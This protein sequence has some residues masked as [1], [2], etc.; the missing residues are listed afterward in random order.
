MNFAEAQ[1][2]AT[3]LAKAGD[4]EGID[5]LMARAAASKIPPAL[6]QLLGTHRENALLY[7]SKNPKS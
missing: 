2:K 6:V 4:V 3:E 5:R 7:L 1:Q